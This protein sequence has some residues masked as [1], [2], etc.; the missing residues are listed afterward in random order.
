MLN[1]NGVAGSAAHWRDVLEAAGYTVARIGDAEATD[2]EETLVVV[3]PGEQPRGA[4]IVDA[5]GFGQVTTGTVE[6]SIDAMVIVGA[7]AAQEASQQG[8]TG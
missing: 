1:G 3:R 2:F 4:S 7:D 6:R 8:S 5:L